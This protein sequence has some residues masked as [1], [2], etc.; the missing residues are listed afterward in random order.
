MPI[1]IGEIARIAA[2]EHVTGR[3]QQG[4]SSVQ[5]F[6]QPGVH[7]FLAVHVLGQG[8][9]AEEAALGR[10]AGILGEFVGREERQPGA[11]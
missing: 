4:R 7:G 11:F 10:Q 6:L 5:G 2:P 3:A 9:P 8:D 1:G